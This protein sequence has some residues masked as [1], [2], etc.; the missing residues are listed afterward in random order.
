MIV[1]KKRERPANL[2][3]IPSVPINP[4]SEAKWV[5]VYCALFDEP[6]SKRFIH[7]VPKPFYKRPNNPFKFFSKLRIIIWFLQEG[8]AFLYQKTDSLNN[9]EYSSECIDSMRGNNNCRASVIE[10]KRND[11]SGQP[12]ESGWGRSLAWSRIPALGA[13]DLRSNR[14][15][16]TMPF[17]SFS[18]KEIKCKLPKER[19]RIFP[20]EKGSKV[21]AW[22]LGQQRDITARGRVR[23]QHEPKVSCASGTTVPDEPQTGE[24]HSP[25]RF[26]GP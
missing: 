8:I 3:S 2:G 21:N 23:K 19:K 5:I 9:F 17:L 10:Q 16:P 14:S 7:S 20:K 25:P 22:Y 6:F 1:K 4:L 13:G 12:I 11:T 15:G 18:E 26:G 24:G